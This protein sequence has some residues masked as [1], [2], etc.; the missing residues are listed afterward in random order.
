MITAPENRTNEAGSARRR[1]TVV[2]SLVIVLGLG[3]VAGTGRWIETN[4]PP[5]DPGLEEERLYLSGTVA[6]RLSLG[7]NGL[8]A[9]W[10]WIRALQYV[11]RKIIAKEGRF[12]L[13][14]LSTLDL[15]LLYPLLDTAITLDPQF[16]AVYEYG[17]VVLP[18]VNVEHAIKLLRKGI[19]NNP[20]EW[21][22]FHHL[23]YIYWQR[24]DY[25]TASETY[26][27][28]SRLPG[29]PPWMRVMSA[30]MLEGDSADT[31]REMYIRIYEESDDAD[32]RRMAELHLMQL[33]S[34]EE[35]NAIRMVLKRFADR[36]GRCANNW[37]EVATALRTAGLRLS[38]GDQPLDPADTGYVLA[39]GGC[40][41]EMDPN[42]PV[43][44]K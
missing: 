40:D 39:S 5:L 34:R 6:R 41:V 35:R 24:K 9:D 44:Y 14:D 29:A 23:G 15:R 13:D 21:R 38:A 37:K 12:Q 32:I 17:G 7:F 4:R 20:S 18:A 31:A 8:M 42:S 33:D 43:P 36:N 25:K 19:E 28:G 2:L 30:R 22:L 16:M 26:A 27:E 11:G 10:Y 1:Q 3:S